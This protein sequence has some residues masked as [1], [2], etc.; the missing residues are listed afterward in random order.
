[1]KRPTAGKNSPSS[2]KKDK[3][4]GGK[5][6]KGS[7]LWIYGLVVCAVGAA[8]ILYLTSRTSTP[9]SAVTTLT[10]DTFSSFVSSNPG[11]ALVYFFI[12]TCS[13]CKELTPHYEAAAEEISKS[14]GAPLATVNAEAEASLAKKFALERYPTML[15]FRKGTNV[16]E[17]G[18]L[19]RTKEKLVEYVEWA[20][21]P[22]LIEF[23]TME[24]FTEALPT[25][26]QTLTP[27][28]AP[29]VVGFEGKENLYDTVELA[30]E[31]LRGKVAFL[32]VREA[33]PEQVG[34]RT[35]ANIENEDQ[36]YVGGFEPDSV[37]RW[38]KG[39]EEAAKAKRKAASAQSSEQTA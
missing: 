7:S 30:A 25:L 8:G 9:A 13:H 2:G 27:T 36:E 29:L 19:T 10:Q 3:K 18:P 4:R 38:A 6:A 26:R 14:G 37:Y 31:K 15:W 5:D 32:F 17:L 22:A 21:Q 12:P 23:Q 28:M 16:L 24:E 39:F 20:S 1:M 33:H 35:Y 34:L 11:G